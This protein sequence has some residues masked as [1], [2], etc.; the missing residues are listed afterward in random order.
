MGPRS[1]QAAQLGRA[2]GGEGP[3]CAGTGRHRP[4][5]LRLGPQGLEVRQAL[6]PIGQRHHHL[7][8]RDPRVMATPRRL[9][10][11]L[12]EPRGQPA[13]IRHL[14]QPHQP[15]TRH[16]TLAIAGHGPWLDQPDSLPH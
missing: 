4:E 1:R 10:C 2:Q 7:R 6:G 14:A 13:P 5:Q 12:A 3:L 16:E 9:G 15:A 8:Q 11:H